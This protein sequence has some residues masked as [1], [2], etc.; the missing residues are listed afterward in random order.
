[1]L[2]VSLRRLWNRRE[3]HDFYNV[4][5]FE[6]FNS[7]QDTLLFPFR[8]PSV[9]EVFLSFFASR[10]ALDLY[11]TSSSETHFARNAS[12]NIIIIRRVF[13]SFFALDVSLGCRACIW[14]KE[15]KTISKTYFFLRR[16]FP[17]A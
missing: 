8:G 15:N 9:V 11:E 12:L 10:P 1:M 5:T 14:K 7:S 2:N 4:I 3:A 13:A 16:S 6:Y 17:S